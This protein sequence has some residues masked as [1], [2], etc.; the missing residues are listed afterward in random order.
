MTIAI[1]R[2]YK[3]K[4]VEMLTAVSTIINQAISNK[5][6]LMGKRSSWKD[7]FFEQVKV[8][9]DNAFTT[10]LG[11][12]SAK[13]MREATQFIQSLQAFTLPLL[14]EFKVQIDVDFKNPKRTEILN[15]LGFVEHLKAVQKLDQEALVELL[16]KFK[17]NM[18]PA[19]Q[20]E[21]TAKGIDTKTI[22]EITKSADNIKDSNISQE[23]F[24][25]GRK[26]LTAAGITEFNTLY[27]EVIAIAK[28]SAKFFKD[29]KPKAEIFSYSR[30]IKSQNAAPKPKPVTP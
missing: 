2:N 12:D 22:D 15:Q 8:R 18:T 1:K 23:A 17:S 30:T 13:E 11:V 26:T 10:H 27:E 3:G 29:D 9:I 6:F 14:A 4:D 5:A 19:L 25:G 16:F 24:K 20:A 7:P 28:I 21:I